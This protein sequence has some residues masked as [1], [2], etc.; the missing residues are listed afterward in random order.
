M[1]EKEI[2]DRINWKNILS[3]IIFGE[4]CIESSFQSKEELLKQ[5]RENEQ[6]ISKFIRMGLS[7]KMNEE[8]INDTLEKITTYYTTLESLNLE[9]GFKIGFSLILQAYR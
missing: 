4:E 3:F 1:N 8:K 6:H 5:I 2:I 7:G 9:L